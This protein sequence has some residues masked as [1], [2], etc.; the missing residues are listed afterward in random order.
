MGR[1]FNPM[2]VSALAFLVISFAAHGWAAEP[3][4]PAAEASDHAT[5]AAPEAF[6]AYQAVADSREP[7][8]VTKLAVAKGAFDARV[9]EVMK[10]DGVTRLAAMQR[11]R[12]EHPDAFAALQS[13]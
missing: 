4:P 2:S 12:K 1:I 13:A 3:S 5:S 6:A 8:P 11:A 10:R 9:A 7:E